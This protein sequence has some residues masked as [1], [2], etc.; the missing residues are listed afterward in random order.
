MGGSVGPAKAMLFPPPRRGSSRS[1]RRAASSSLPLFAAVPS[2]PVAPAPASL[3]PKPWGGKGC[4]P[5]RRDAPGRSEWT[6]GAP[7]V[8]VSEACRREALENLDRGFYAASSIAAV[9]AR[10]RTI[11]TLLA[12]WGL[13][14]APVTASV[15]KALGASLK[16]GGYRSYDSVMSQLKVDAERD[17][18]SWTPQL[19]RLY[20]DVCR[21][22]RRGLGPPR[23]ALPLPFELLADLSRIRGLGCRV[24]RSG[25][26]TRSS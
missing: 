25:A 24:V 1:P 16:A 18:E 6:R 5:L 12:P 10:R 7:P 4:P 22:C 14:P 13:S 9:Q 23:Q 15:L 21:S 17:G 20:T 8:L 26:G 11:R 2:S 3:P 19:R